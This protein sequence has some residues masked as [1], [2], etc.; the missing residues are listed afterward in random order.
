MYDTRFAIRLF[1]V[2]RLNRCKSGNI[3]EKC[4][5][6]R[7]SSFQG[8]RNEHPNY[9]EDLARLDAEAL[10]NAGEK[11]NWGTDESE[12]HRLL[13]SKSYQHLRHVFSEYK[14]LASKD[15]EESIKSEFS[16]DVCLGLLSLG[17]QLSLVFRFSSFSSNVLR[18]FS[19]HA[20]IIIEYRPQIN[21]KRSNSFVCIYI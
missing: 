17:T 21:Q 7:F 18:S 11:F 12:F 1:V 19:V 10:Y 13:T 9:D 6:E 2:C 3:I 5:R 4:L 20:T 8:N 16:G 15:I 14:R